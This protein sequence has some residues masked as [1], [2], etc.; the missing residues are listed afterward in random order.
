MVEIGKIIKDL[1][2]KK[3]HYNLMY[4]Q[5]YQNFKEY[6]ILVLIKDYKLLKKW[7][8]SPSSYREDITLIQKIVKRVPKKRLCNLLNQSHL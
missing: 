8:I 5:I 6:V 7:K 2:L 3:M 4:S 1:P